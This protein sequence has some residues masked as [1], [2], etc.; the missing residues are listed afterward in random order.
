MNSKPLVS[1]VIPVYK[2][3]KYLE[4]CIM[5]VINSTYDN[6]S[7]VLVDDGSPD[8]CPAICDSFKER[9][10][11]V[12]VVHKPNG[13]LSTARNAGLDAA[14]KSSKYLLFLD[15]DDEIIADAIEGMVEVAERENASVVMPDRYVKIIEQTGERSVAKH[16]PECMYIGNARQFAL[17]VMIEQ[18]RAWRAHSLLYSYRAVIDSNARFP[19]GHISEDISFN[20]QVLFYVDSISF[21]NKPTVNYLKRA[22]SITTTYQPNFE[23]DIWYIDAQVREFLD[24]IGLDNGVGR[25]K[26]DALL[27]RNIV[28]YLFSIMSHKNSMEYKDKVK[29][30]QSVI[31]DE[32]ARD[33]VRS[34]HKTPYFESSKKRFAMSFIYFLLRTR[35]DKLAFRLLSVL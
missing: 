29:K 2:T 15:S 27:C 9:Y 3:E 23:K 35:Q 4:K 28:V 34:K 19:E 21:Y 8:G 20:L 22:G 11:N 6:L 14:D 18:G 1:V 12:T 16:F 7:I 33:V 31:N 10:G 5:S 32:H 26:A 13:G 24:N 30:A 17:D 25:E